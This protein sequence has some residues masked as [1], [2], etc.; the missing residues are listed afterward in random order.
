MSVLRIFI[1]LFV[2]IT[3]SVV[4]VYAAP[5]TAILDSGIAINEILIDPNS[6]AS[7]FDTDNNGTADSRDEFIELYNLSGS[8]I[9]ISNWELWDSGSGNWFAFPPGTQLVSGAYATVVIGVQAGGTLP[10][11][12]NPDS[13]I[14]DAGRGTSV[15]N[16][17]G[18]N[19]V[20]Y[21]PGNDEYI[22]LLFNGDLPDDPTITYVGFS[23]TAIRVGPI[24]DW[25]SDQ[26]TRSLTRYPSGDTAIGVHDVIT[27]GGQPASPT[28]VNLK[29]FSSKS[30]P[31]IE[32]IFIVIVAILSLISVVIIFRRQTHQNTRP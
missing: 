10:T 30:F 13:V 19:V 1:G 22:Q 6:G 32:T 20:L 29:S 27:P 9:D 24:E 5:T 26:D 2:L 23:G 8:T 3:I 11:M 31:S 21:D 12:T 7:G 4:E 18:D 15:I 17:G 16:N 14:F 28:A 25:G